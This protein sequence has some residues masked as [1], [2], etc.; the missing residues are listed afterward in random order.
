MNYLNLFLLSII[1]IG[2]KKKTF[3]DDIV[4]SFPKETKMKIQ[5]FNEDS[6]EGEEN[7]LYMGKLKQ[8]IE[9][10][11]YKNIMSEP[12]PPPKKQE[13]REDYSIRIIKFKDSINS[14]TS[15]FFKTAEIPILFGKNNDSFLD[16]L[17]N[18]NIKIIVKINDT[19]PLYKE[20]YSTKAK[21]KYYAFPV[22]IKNISNKVLRIP[23]TSKN[24]ALYIDDSDMKNLF[25]IRNSNYMICGI[26][27]D[28]YSYFE[29]KPN[30]ILIYGFPYLE[31]GTK[32]KAKMK[33]YN[34]S[35]KEFEISIDEKIIKNQRDRHFLQ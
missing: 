24:V 18:K 23:T 26:E 31:K 15:S 21:K 12:P 20:D 22:F 3:A 5:E 13:S 33:F 9:V 16:S 1:L 35:S 14:Q 28:F 4:L 7:L 17:S 19:I 30:E 25:F 27:T 8:N 10:K 34:A 6:N 11:Y 2:C 29:L 32:R